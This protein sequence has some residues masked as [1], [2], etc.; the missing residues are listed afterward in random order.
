MEKNSFLARFLYFVYST[1]RSHFSF[2]L[3]VAGISTSGSC[4]EQLGI[5]CVPSYMPERVYPICFFFL[6]A[7]FKLAAVFPSDFDSL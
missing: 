3:N 6:T 7:F 1:F 4:Q 5:L 2:L